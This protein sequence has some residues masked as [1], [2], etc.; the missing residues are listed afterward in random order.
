MHFQIKIILKNNRNHTPKQG[1]LFEN[2][3]FILFF[4][5]KNI[6][7]IFSHLFNIL[8]LKIIF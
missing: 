8:I 2:I 5:L 3:L 7:F 6:V 4:L 1:H